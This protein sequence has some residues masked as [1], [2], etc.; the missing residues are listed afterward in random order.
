MEIIGVIKLIVEL[1]G[2]NCI[3]VHNFRVLNIKTYHD[4]LC[5]RDFMKHYEMK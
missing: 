3:M 4:I 2:T 5:G 1:K